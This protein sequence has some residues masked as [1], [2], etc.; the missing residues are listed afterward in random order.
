M[1]LFACSVVSHLILHPV[2]ANVVVEKRYPKINLDIMVTLIFVHVF[3][4]LRLS[5]STLLSKK[6]HITVLSMKNLI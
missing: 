4:S 3:L 1:S 6:C 5:N 2:K